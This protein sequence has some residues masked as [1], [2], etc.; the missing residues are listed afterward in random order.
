MFVLFNISEQTGHPAG[1]IKDT[2]CVLRLFWFNLVLKWQ[3]K[4]K[5]R[6]FFNLLLWL[7]VFYNRIVTYMCF[8]LNHVKYS[9]SDWFLFIV[10]LLTSNLF[11][12][13][14]QLLNVSYSFTTLKS[15]VFNI[16]T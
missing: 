2:A 4:F 10:W 14:L 3:L 1:V 11:T 16:K 5:I 13:F 7:L 15:I 6:T 9:I 8:I 12:L